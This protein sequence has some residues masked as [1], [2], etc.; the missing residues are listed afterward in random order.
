MADDTDAKEIDAK[1]LAEQFLD[2]WQ[3]QLGALSRDPEFARAAGQGM[4][5][6][7]R[8]LAGMAAGSAAGA[9]GT[10]GTVP[11]PFDAF[12][13]AM[14]SAGDAGKAQSATADAGGNQAGAK[15]AAAASGDCGDDPADLARRLAAL[16]ERL[17]RLEA[18]TGGDG[19]K[20]PPKRRSARRKAG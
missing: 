6:W 16:E 15:T 1:E 9:T 18:G 12:F 7:S 11:A 19:G 17:A 10:P 13:N 2:L 14:R 20:T 3:Q 8:M 5:L 4:Q